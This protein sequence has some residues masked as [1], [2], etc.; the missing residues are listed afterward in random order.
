MCFELVQ[1]G[2]ESPL[3]AKVRAACGVDDGVLQGEVADGAEEAETGEHD[4]SVPLRELGAD[5]SSWHISPRDPSCIHCHELCGRSGSC[6]R[7][8]AWSA[9]W[10]RTHRGCCR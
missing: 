10:R 6:P 8:T 7:N 5:R 1:V 9:G 2:E 3:T 4:Q